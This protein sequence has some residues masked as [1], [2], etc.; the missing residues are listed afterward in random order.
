MKRISSVNNHG[1]CIEL[2]GDLSCTGMS[3]VI[4]GGISAISENLENAY[5]GAVSPCEYNPNCVK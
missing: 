4:P 2:F 5:V 3:Q 1:N